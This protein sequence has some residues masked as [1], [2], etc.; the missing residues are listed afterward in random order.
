MHLPQHVPVPTHTEAHLLLPVHSRLVQRKDGE[1]VQRPWKLRLDV[2]HHDP[3]FCFSS[4][5]R[6]TRFTCDWSSDVCSSDLIAYGAFATST[7]DQKRA[8]AQ[9]IANEIDANNNQIDILDEQYNAA[10]L[11]VAQLNKSIASAKARSEERR[12]GRECSAAWPPCTR[13]EG[14]S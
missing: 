7:L 13:D 6:H 10:V 5:R 3:K 11:K 9:H 2:L 14:R 4:R 8:E 12:V 1:M